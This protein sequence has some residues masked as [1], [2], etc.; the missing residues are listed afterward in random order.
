MFHRQVLQLHQRNWTHQL[1]AFGDHEL[2]YLHNQL[3][4]DMKIAIQL[5]YAWFKPKTFLPNRRSRHHSKV[6]YR[7]KADKNPCLHGVLNQLSHMQDMAL[8][9][10]SWAEIMTVSLEISL[11]TQSNEPLVNYETWN[12][13]K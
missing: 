5:T 13:R 8:D 9:H 10:P 11:D 12:F 2:K 4:K 6:E 1:F 3:T 7:S